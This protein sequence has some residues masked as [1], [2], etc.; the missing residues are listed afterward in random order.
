MSIDCAREIEKETG[1][2]PKHGAPGTQPLEEAPPTRLLALSLVINYWLGW[3]NNEK[4]MDAS[5]P[6]PFK[7]WDRIHDAYM[8]GRHHS[9]Q[10]ER[11]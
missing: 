9:E 6:Q 7:A 4:N 1:K 10:K 5:I 11:S 8:A 2:Y 3:V